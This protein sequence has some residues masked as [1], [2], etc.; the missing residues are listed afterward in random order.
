VLSGANITLYSAKVD[1][2]QNQEERKKERKRLKF[3]VIHYKY[4]CE[5]EG[6]TH[7]IHFVLIHL[8]IR[9][10]GNTSSWRL[11]VIYL[12]VWKAKNLHKQKNMHY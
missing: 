5:L 10:D 1:R 12:G 9:T 2:G 11:V 8:P 3:A 7:C 6:L 4:E